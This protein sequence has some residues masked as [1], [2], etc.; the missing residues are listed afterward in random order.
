MVGPQLQQEVLY[1]QLLLQIVILL[2]VE[3]ALQMSLQDQE[4]GHL[5]RLFQVYQNLPNILLKG[6]QQTQ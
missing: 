4:Q 2:L 5:M 3:L 1:T 6:M